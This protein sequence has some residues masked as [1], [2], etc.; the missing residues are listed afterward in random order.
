MMLLLLRL[1]LD[2]FGHFKESCHVMTFFEMIAA[3]QYNHNESFAKL[4]S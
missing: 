2:G 4:D 3:I 1:D